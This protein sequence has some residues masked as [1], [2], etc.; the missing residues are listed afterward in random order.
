MSVKN[1]RIIAHKRGNN[2]SFT[3][4][5][6]D[7]DVPVILDIANIRCEIRDEDD[8]LI[9][10][11]IVTTDGVGG[12]TLTVA[13]TYSWAIG[14]LFFDI[15]ITMEGTTSISDIYEFEVIKNI[16]QPVS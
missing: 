13:N 5:L 15:A 8:T 6:T 11:C 16:T 2:F 14:K 10:T 7:D 4:N 9:D 1:K 12:Y 3:M